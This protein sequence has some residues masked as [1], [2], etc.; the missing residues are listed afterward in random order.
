MMSV[1]ILAIVIMAW[2]RISKGLDWTGDR[3]GE[4]GDMLSDLTISGAKQTSRG[5]V[6]SHGS[7]KDTVDGEIKKDVTRTREMTKFKKGLTAEEIKE[8]KTSEDYYASILAR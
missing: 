7:L 3:I 1:A 6:I 4:T 2:G 5:V 8:V